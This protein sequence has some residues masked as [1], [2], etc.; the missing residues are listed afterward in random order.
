MVSK[1]F[2][3][4]TIYKYNKRVRSLFDRARGKIFCVINLNVYSIIYI[5]HIFTGYAIKLWFARARLNS[6][7]SL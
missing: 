7:K 6:F 2:K 3:Q 4:K 5:R 1:D